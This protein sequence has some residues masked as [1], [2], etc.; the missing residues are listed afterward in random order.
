MYLYAYAQDSA[1]LIYDSVVNALRSVNPLK[2]KAT[3]NVDPATPGNDDSTTQVFKRHCPENRSEQ[4]DFIS[5]LP[6]GLLL[7]VASKLEVRDLAIL[8]QVSHIF[9][10]V[11]NGVDVWKTFVHIKQ[12]GGE[13]HAKV[14]RI[15]GPLAFASLPEKDLEGHY[16]EYYQFF[17]ITDMTSP[18]MK[19]KD[20]AGRPFVAFRII[21]RLFQERFGI[22][23]FQ[24][25]VSDKEKEVFGIRE[26]AFFQGSTEENFKLIE[27]LIRHEPIGS[28]LDGKESESKVLPDGRSIVELD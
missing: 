7:I 1:S 14:A 21:D 8:G 12:T 10:N 11:V 27:R 20:S 17:N 6:E 13:L 5:Q 24:C 23:V 15:M 16:H 25:D 19:G 2:R 22:A 9:H 4:K 3:G 18:M 28:I 26:S